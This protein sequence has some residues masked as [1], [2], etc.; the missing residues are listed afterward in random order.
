[1]TS[2]I[3][4]GALLPD[5]GVD[6]SLV[7]KKKWGIRRLAKIGTGKTNIHFDMYGG[8]VCHDAMA[9]LGE[10][11]GLT[12]LIREYCGEDCTLSETGV[13]L[14]GPSGG[15]LEWHI[16]GAEG[17]CTVIMSLDDVQPEQGMLGLVLGSHTMLDRDAE[18]DFDVQIE[19]VVKREKR[20]AY[21]YR[22]GKPIVFDARLIHSAEE[23]KS[24]R[25][26]VILWWIYN[27]G[28]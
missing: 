14:T 13:S 1:M 6:S 27:G 19:G 20:S 21:A 11:N 4:E 25:T 22:A 12:A 26:R 3:M 8:S 23:S 5:G 2:E 9:K 28:Q 15:G 24:E 10:D 16:D 17:E 18:E 7:D